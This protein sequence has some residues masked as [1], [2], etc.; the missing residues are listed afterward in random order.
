MD[1]ESE[2]RLNELSRIAR[3]RMDLAAYSPNAVFAEIHY[4]T[5]DELFE[6]MA[7]RNKL[8]SFGQMAIEAKERIMIKIDLRRN[9]KPL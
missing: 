4:M 1:K 6:F 3:S 9:L 7:L 2:I 8:P 5:S